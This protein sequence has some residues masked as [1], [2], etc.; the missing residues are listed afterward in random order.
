MHHHQLGARLRGDPRGATDQSLRFRPAGHRDNHPLAGFPGVGDLLVGTVLR[1]RRIDLVG[2]P[3]QRDRAQRRQIAG[4]KIVRQCGVDTFRRVDV[5]VSEPAPQ[6]LRCNI[7]QFDL[8][9]FADD[10]VGNGLALFDAGDLSYDVVEA[11]Q[12]LDVDCRDHVDAGVEQRF[13][14]LPTFGIGAARDVAVRVFVDQRDLWATPQNRLD[15]EF[16]EILVA[17]VDDPRRHHLYALV[18]LGDF[19]AAVGLDN[20]RDNV[21]AALRP[22]VRLAQH[23]AGLAHAWGRAEINAQLT[24]SARW[25]LLWLGS[26]NCH[27]LRERAI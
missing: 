21:G 15:V 13:D 18:E 10:V 26:R 19:L 12:V 23:G 6:R 14:V 17:V 4:T 27:C 9:R 22:A 11:F 8:S 7:D 25:R 1:Q 20:G 3:Q 5:A 2:Q 24:A 16:G